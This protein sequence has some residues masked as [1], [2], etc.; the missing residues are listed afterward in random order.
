[1]GLAPRFSSTSVATWTWQEKLVEVHEWNRVH[2]P[3]SWIE[4]LSAPIYSPPLWFAVS[5]LQ[6]CEEGSPTMGC[7]DAL[8]VEE[9]IV[10]G[11]CIDDMSGLSVDQH[12]QYWKSKQN[13]YE[14]NS[15]SLT[16][17]IADTIVNKFSIDIHSS[18]LLNYHTRIG[19][20]HFSGTRQYSYISKQRINSF[21]Y[22]SLSNLSSD[23]LC[24][25]C[26]HAIKG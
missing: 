26:V 4:F 13:S 19:C 1:L 24:V 3:N 12:K 20:N 9:F 15:F 7:D 25:P 8:E 10:V 21:N 23:G 5:V 16:G 11:D 22:A 2:R 14:I 18:Y 17:K 6:P